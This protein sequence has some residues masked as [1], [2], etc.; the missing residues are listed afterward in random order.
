MGHEFIIGLDKGADLQPSI[1]LML[2]GAVPIIVLIIAQILVLVLAL[3][4]KAA[5]GPTRL[6]WA[7]AIVF[8]PIVGMIAYMF[9]RGGRRIRGLRSAA[10]TGAG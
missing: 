4:D 7:I 10:R 3:T 6:A 1:G 2:L 8:A 5:P 9:A